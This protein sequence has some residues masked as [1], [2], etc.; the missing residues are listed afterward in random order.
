MGE[1]QVSPYLM[2][3]HIRELENNLRYLKLEYQLRNWDSDSGTIEA[4]AANGEL[5]MVNVTDY[6]EGSDFWTL[7][8]F[9][10]VNSYPSKRTRDLIE[11]IE[12]GWM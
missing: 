11:D 1:D 9:L 3:E 6:C 2:Y 10:C 8:G 4:H 7:A 5:Q 12:A